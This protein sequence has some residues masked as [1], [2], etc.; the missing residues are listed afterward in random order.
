MIH[1]Y[2]VLA[3]SLVNVTWLGVV[4]HTHLTMFLITYVAL[5]PMIL[6]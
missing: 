6:P 3:K 5:L 4:Y 2:V 1:Q